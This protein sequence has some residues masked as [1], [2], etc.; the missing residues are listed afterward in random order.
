MSGSVA[1]VVELPVVELPSAA[2]LPVELPVLDE[3]PV[4]SAELVVPGLVVTPGV[5]KPVDAAPGPL[6]AASAPRATVTVRRGRT[7]RR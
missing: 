2:P 1:S 5:V 4:D 7:M 6:Q 3:P